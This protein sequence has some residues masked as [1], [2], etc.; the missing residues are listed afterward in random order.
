[1]DGWPREIDRIQTTCV[2]LKKK[3]KIFAQKNETNAYWF[4]ATVKNSKNNALNNP[5]SVIF[6]C[7]PLDNGMQQCISLF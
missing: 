3:K 2:L 7:V 5:F 6:C 4:D 1:M